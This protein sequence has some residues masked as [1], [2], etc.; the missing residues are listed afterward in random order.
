MSAR[1]RRTASECER[2][3]LL[4]GPVTESRASGGFLATSCLTG[5]SPAAPAMTS[6]DRTAEFKSAAKLMQG[7][8]V[9]GSACLRS[10]EDKGWVA[11]DRLEK[12]TI[13]SPVQNT[14]WNRLHVQIGSVLF[15]TGSVKLPTVFFTLG[16]Q[17][18]DQGICLSARNG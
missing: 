11:A 7:T 14:D 17:Q 8:I 9:S 18:I 4:R 13:A 12:K 2:E 3:G 15:W 5:G 6:R 10:H 1:R 16:L